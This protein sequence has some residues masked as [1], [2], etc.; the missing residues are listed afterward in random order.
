MPNLKNS[1]LVC[2][3]YANLERE[4]LNEDLGSGNQIMTRSKKR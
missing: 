4:N 3:D 1:L 2:D